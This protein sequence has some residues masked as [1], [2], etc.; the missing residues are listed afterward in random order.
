MRAQFIF[1][2]TL[3]VR[4]PSG[5]PRALL[6]TIRE[7]VR[8]LDPELTLI[9]PRT[10]AQHVDNNLFMQRVPAR[11]LSVL[12]P[13]AL[14]LS[15]IGVYAVLAYSLAQRTREI[16]VRLTLGATPSSVVRFMIWQH[17][18][19]VLISTAVGWVL[20]L[21]LNRVIGS[22]LVGVGIGDPLV[23]SAVPALLLGVAVLACWLPARRAAGVDPMTAL[24]AE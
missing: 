23:Y 4:A 15:A 2:P 6:G 16:A 18:R 5:D 17:M 21:A 7:T 24:R 14:V 9:E 12:G 11:M 8:G 13:L 10:L 19:V 3:H 22:T 20:A 1:S